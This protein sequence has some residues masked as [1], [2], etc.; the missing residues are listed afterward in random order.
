MDSSRLH[1][2]LDHVKGLSS[3]A[4]TGTLWQVAKPA[5][6]EGATLT[7]GG[8]LIEA[9]LPAPPLARLALL[10]AFLAFGSFWTTKRHKA[11]HL[12]H[13]AIVTA[14]VL[15]STLLVLLSRGYGAAASSAIML[16]TFCA[17]FFGYR[18][19]F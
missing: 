16:A 7:S 11:N 13:S 19:A 5:F 15:V 14:M 8:Y 18:R 3:H 10:L 12:E 17:L 2:S 6:I 4:L 1:R 9:L